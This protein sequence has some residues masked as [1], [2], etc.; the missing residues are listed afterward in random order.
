MAYTENQ[1]TQFD[2]TNEYM[3]MFKWNIE[4]LSK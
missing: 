1:H 4:Y 2:K 3:Y